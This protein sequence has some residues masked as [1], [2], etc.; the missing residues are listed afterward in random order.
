MYLSIFIIS[1][2]FIE[3]HLITNYFFKDSKS[4]FHWSYAH[5]HDSEG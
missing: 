1:F 4:P 5:P 3:A 2:F